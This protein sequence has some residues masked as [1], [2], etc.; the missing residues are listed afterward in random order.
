[1]SFDD[2]AK[3]LGG[4]R[5]GIG[6]SSGTRDPDQIMAEA[7]RAAERSARIRDL[8]LGPMLL[9]GGATIAVLWFSVMRQRSAIIHN[10]GLAEQRSTLVGLGPMI[11]WILVAAVAGILLG[12]RKILRGIGV[13]TR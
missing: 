5:G 8:V 2:L 11:H 13:L 6:D 10:P 9:V 12:T 3:R 4:P 1:M 7:Q